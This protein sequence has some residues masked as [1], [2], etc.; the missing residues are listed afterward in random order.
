MKSKKRE[1]LEYYLQ[2]A[3]EVMEPFFGET[4]ID[5]YTKATDGDTALHKFAWRGD[6][7]AVE[8]L[9]D[10]GA[11]IDEPGDLS[12][13]PLYGAVTQGHTEV[14][15]L[16]LERGANPDANNELSCTPRQQAE[17]A[18][19]KETKKLFKERKS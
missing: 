9:L 1:S 2:K 4:I 17:K 12:L 10:E 5:V 18:R 6:R 8:L 7:Y 13:T 3:S 19:S 14:V 16:L 11:H 15:K